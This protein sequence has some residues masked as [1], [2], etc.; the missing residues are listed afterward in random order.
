M[1]SMMTLTTHGIREGFKEDRPDEA[2]V[3][4]R[5]KEKAEEDE[6]S[7]NQGKEKAEEKGK[8]TALTW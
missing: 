4:E 5:G 3:K 6:G 2:M 1:F 8:K 7:S